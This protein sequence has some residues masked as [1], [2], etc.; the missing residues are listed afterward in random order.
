MAADF[1]SK[2]PASN[3]DTTAFT[4]TMAS[5]ASD[6]NLLAGRASTAVDNRTNL[7]LDIIIG[8]QVVT[9]TSPTVNTFIEIWLYTDMSIASGTATYPDS[10][11]GSDANKTVTSTNVKVSAL[12]RLKVITVDNT[13]GRAYPI[14]NISLSQILGFVPEF[15]GVFVVHNTGVALNAT[16]TTGL[17]YRRMQYQ[18]V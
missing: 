18:S 10:I 6:T 4:L 9:G 5:L 14:G 1:K 8:G 11:T 17:N 12:H 3:G 7:D 13:T 2:Y 15:F 16:Q